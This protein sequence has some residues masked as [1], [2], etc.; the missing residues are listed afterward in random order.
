MKRGTRKYTI[1]GSAKERAA[2]AGPGAVPGRNG[3]SSMSSSL[4]LSATLLYLYS[5][6][7]LLV[8]KP[9]AISFC[10][11]RWQGLCLTMPGTVVDHG[12]PVYQQ[13]GGYYPS[14]GYVQQGYPAA[15]YPPAGGYAPAPPAGYAPGETEHC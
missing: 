14:G 10:S 3:T 7:Y 9:C 15:G 8:G 5:R 11:F 2:I 12:P 13:T 6:G 1:E 4:L